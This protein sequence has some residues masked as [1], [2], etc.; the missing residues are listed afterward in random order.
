VRCRL[1]E[2]GFE[3][4]AQEPGFMR[5]LVRRMNR[6]LGRRQTENEPTAAD[7][8][9]RE[10]EHVAKESSIRLRILA[11]NDDVRAGDQELVVSCYPQ[12]GWLFETQV[13][14]AG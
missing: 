3:I 5:F 9:V 11:V 6:D 10:F 13:I 12:T 1:G 8:Y 14:L 4:I 7:V 2:E